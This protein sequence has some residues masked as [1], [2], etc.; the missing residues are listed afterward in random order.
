VLNGIGAGPAETAMPT[1]IADVIFL[2]DRG[3]YQTLYFA[4]YFGSL[5]VGPIISGPMALYVGWRNFWWLNS[6][7]LAFTVLCCI[8]LFPETKYNRSITTDNGNGLSASPPLKTSSTEIENS[9]SHI[10]RETVAKDH[11]DPENEAPVQSQLPTQDEKLGRIHTHDGKSHHILVAK[12]PFPSCLLSC[13]LSTLSI[14][15]R[16]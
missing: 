3:K 8:F 4:F 1:I 5:M 14:V 11:A 16:Q 6:A 13:L 9:N 15:V 12:S 10:G 7:L 2:H